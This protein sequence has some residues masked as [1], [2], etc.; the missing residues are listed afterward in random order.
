MLV[1]YVG[2]PS[3]V[4]TLAGLL[5][6]QGL[7]QKILP[8]GNLNIGDPFVR[9]I[10]RVL[11]PDTLGLILAGLLVLIMI[12]LA[13]RRQSQRKTLGLE[14]DST[15]SIFAQVLFFALLIFALLCLALLWFALNCLALHC[16]ALHCLAFHC[17]ALHCLAL[18]CNAL[19]SLAMPCFALLS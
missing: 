11:L 10:A 4:V 6:Y 2:I 8:T 19:L 1:A 5:G 9:G 16:L 15:L 17:L 13:M 3:F 12:F 18:L 14:L 7:M